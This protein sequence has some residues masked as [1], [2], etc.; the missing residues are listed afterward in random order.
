MN[1]QQ[2]GLFK[3]L[4]FFSGF[5]V[6]AVAF[7]IL[8]LPIPEDG[9]SDIQKFI[10]IEIPL[11]Y[12]IFIVPL[13]FSSISSRNIDTKIT[14]TVHIWLGVS[15]FE[16]TAITL[17]VLVVNEVIPIKNAVLV[18]LVLFFI[19]AIFVY[20][21]Y[22]A[23]NRIGKVQNEE[24]QSL[25]KIADLKEAFKMLSLKSD[26]WSDELYEQK[27][28]IKKLCD[29]VCYISPVDNDVALNMESK[30]LILA[31][32]LTESPLTPADTETK[33]KE[34]ADLISQRK[35]LTKQ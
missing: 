35:L 25:N 7:M 17:I 26:T 14:S 30:L 28:K 29:D 8:N 19:L 5:V 21:G 20:F 2:L 13:F 33:I 15:I 12:L 31:N 16:M 34:I 11:C 18:E 22:F 6:I 3:I 23:G 4:L 10:W 1:T 27:V 32:L 24:Q 9:L